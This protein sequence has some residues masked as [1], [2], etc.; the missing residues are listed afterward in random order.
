MKKGFSFIELLVIIAIIALLIGILMPA[1]GKAKKRAN[2]VKAKNEQQ[3]LLHNE[4]KQKEFINGIRY[5]I[6]PKT[7]VIFAIMPDGTALIVPLDQ[8]DNVWGQIE[9]IDEWEGD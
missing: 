9:N 1:L 3:E 5:I 4:E 6:D 7:G 2:D 8:Y